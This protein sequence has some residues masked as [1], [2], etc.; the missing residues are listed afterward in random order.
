MAR[1]TCDRRR[2]WQPAA[3]L[4]VGGLLVNDRYPPAGAHARR[5]WTLRHNLTHYDALDVALVS[6]LDIPLL[7]ADPRLRRASVLTCHTE[8][9]SLRPVHPR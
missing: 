3:A 7:T 1:T 9:V 4:R 6:H 2:V 5:A 8:L